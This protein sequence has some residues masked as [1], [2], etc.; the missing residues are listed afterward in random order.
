LQDINFFGVE[1]VVRNWPLDTD[2]AIAIVARR[3]HT[4]LA[5]YGAGA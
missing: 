5:D 1:V 4:F 2:K 3:I